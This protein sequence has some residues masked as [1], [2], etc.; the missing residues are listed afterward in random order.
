MWLLWLVMELAGVTAGSATSAA[1]PTASV[2][3]RIADLVMRHS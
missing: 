2:K 3:S 1:A